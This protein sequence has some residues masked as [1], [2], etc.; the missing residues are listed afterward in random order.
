MKKL[1]VAVISCGMIANKGH[2]PAYRHYADRCELAAVCDLNPQAA[3]DTAERFGVR[4]M[5]YGRGENAGKRAAGPGL[6]MRSQRAS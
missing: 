2:L 1:K 6:C 4:K 3:Q 5:V